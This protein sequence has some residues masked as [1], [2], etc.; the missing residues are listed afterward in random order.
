M[1]VEDAFQ[2]LVKDGPRDLDLMGWMS[3]T[4][5]ELIGQGGAGHSF[6]TLTPGSEKSSTVGE[7]LK[8]FVSVSATC[9]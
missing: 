3:R 6:D 4:A 7:A 1:Q 2:H 9:E 8:N 5:L